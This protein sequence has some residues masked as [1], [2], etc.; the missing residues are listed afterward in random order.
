[1][2]Q[3]DKKKR[4]GEERESKN[5]GAWAMHYLLAFVFPQPSQV[6]KHPQSL[7][8]EFSFIAWLA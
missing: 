5:S 6:S 2:S 4:R 8:Q 7:L 1:L 3:T